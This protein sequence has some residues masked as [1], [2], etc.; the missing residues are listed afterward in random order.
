MVGSARRTRPV[1]ES[2]RAG[3]RTG[4]F[5]VACMN[6]A[7]NDARILTWLA[8][9]E[10]ETCAVVAGLITRTM[11]LDARQ[12]VQQ[13]RGVR[14]KNIHGRGRT[15]GTSLD[16]VALFMAR[17]ASG[18]WLRAG[19]R[20][21]LVCRGTV[22]LLVGYLAFRLALAAHGRAGEPASSAGAVQAAIA[23]DGGGSRWSCS[24]LVSARTRLPSSSRRCSGLPARI[25]RPPGGVSVRCRCGDVCCT[26]PSA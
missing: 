7:G 5:R 24:S 17:G 16:A 13:K 10:P 26:Q 8:H 15:A 3:E 18:V 21:G 19:S 6:R 12:T 1:R 25:A 22:Y 11:S 20:L 14:L 23:S 2:R 4:R 9:W